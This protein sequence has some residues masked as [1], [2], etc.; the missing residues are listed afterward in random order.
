MNKVTIKSL[1]SANVRMDNSADAE[2][3]YDIAANVNIESGNTLSNIDSGTV[4]REAN[5]L[6]TFGSWGSG[7]LQINYNG[8]SAEEQCAI[9]TAV[10]QFIAAA[11]SKAAESNP[12]A[13]AT[14]T[15]AN[16]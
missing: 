1:N 11:R 5:E 2:R 16:E 13:V 9:I 10:N 6:A 14:S 15:V 8:V 7:N 4:R 3:V 12:L